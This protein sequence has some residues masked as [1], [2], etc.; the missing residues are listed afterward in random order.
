MYLLDYAGSSLRHEGFF[1]SGCWDLVPWSGI[2][3][4]PPVLETR[5]LSHWTTNC[6]CLVDKSRL[7]LCDPMDC[8]PAR[9]LC[10]WDFPGKSTG[11]GGH[12]L[13]QGIFPTQGLSRSLLHWQVGCLPRSHE[14]NPWTTRGIPISSICIYLYY[15]HI[16]IYLS[17]SIMCFI[18]FYLYLFECPKYQYFT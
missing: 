14:G 16:T 3:L 11:V 10:P 12:F 17:I 4:S 15:M 13:L 1:S 6:C 5:S 8:N 7:T 2:E 18:Y 9:H